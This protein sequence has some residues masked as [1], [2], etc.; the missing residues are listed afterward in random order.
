MNIIVIIFIS[1]SCNREETTITIPTPPVNTDPVTPQN[2]KT[3]MV[4]KN[5]TTETAALFYNLRNLGKTKTVIGQHDAFNSFY[6]S[7]GDSD[8]KKTTGNDPGILGS[9]FMFIT[10]KNNP[11]NSWYVQ[12]ENKIIQDEQ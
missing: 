4:D 11:S 10:D 8:I 2:V 3:Y 7:S 12:Q 6:Q 5:A 9:D 1:F